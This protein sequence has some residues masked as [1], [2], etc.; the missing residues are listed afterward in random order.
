[1]ALRLYESLGIQ[2][3]EAERERVMRQ[4]TQNVAALLAYGRGLEAE[5]AANY[6]AAA[7][8]FA[9]SARLDPGFAAARASQQRVASSAAASAVDTRQLAAGA[10]I[11]ASPAPADP[12]FFLPSPMTR[13]PAAEFLRVEGV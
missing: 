6:A 5:D 8:H 4:P 3:T 11:E 13:D 1:V 10:Q 12:D 7:Q 9:E 2:L